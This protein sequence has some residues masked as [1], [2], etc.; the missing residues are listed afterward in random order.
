MRK[1]KMVRAQSVQ[2]MEEYRRKCNEVRKA[3]RTDT[4]NWLQEQCSNIE[5]H[6]THETYK[7]LKKISGSWQ[8]RWR[9]SDA[10]MEKCCKT[11]KRQ[12]ID[13]QSTAELYIK[14]RAQMK[15]LYSNLRGWHLHH[16]LTV[17]FLSCMPPQQKRLN[18]VACMMPPA[19]RFAVR[20]C[21]SRVVLIKN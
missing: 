18:R 13:G 9:V 4:E 1:L 17:P 8:L 5:Q 2:K 11:R 21:L 10:K 14:T 19:T 12:R 3:A 16:Y 7:L 20:K 15:I 6:R